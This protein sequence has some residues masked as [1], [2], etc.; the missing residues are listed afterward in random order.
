MKRLWQN[1][2]FRW[3]ASIFGATA[4]P[5]AVVTLGVY[6][7]LSLDL[8][9]DPDENMFRGVIGLALGLG[10]VSVATLPIDPIG[11]FLIGVLYLPVAGWLL[12]NWG[13]VVGL[14][15]VWGGR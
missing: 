3:G 2:A 8:V 11:R 13:F 5:V 6:S 1:Y 7:L 10:I 14:G 12:V 9:R 15:L 4:L